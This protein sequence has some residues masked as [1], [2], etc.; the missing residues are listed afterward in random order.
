MEVK[1]SVIRFF[2]SE[3][4]LCNTSTVLDHQEKFIFFDTDDYININ[5]AFDVVKYLRYLIK[6]TFQILIS[7]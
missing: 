4:K 7:F 3:L 2:K 6:T 5:S 1:K